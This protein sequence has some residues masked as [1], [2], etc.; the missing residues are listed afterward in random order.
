ML[1]FIAT[2]MECMIVD[3]PTAKTMFYELLSFYMEKEEASSRQYWATNKAEKGHC[4][5]SHISIEFFC[6]TLMELENLEIQKAF[7]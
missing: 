1:S 5:L 6:M 4:R 2:K 3:R 7:K